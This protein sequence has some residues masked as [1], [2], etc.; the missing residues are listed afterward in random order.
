MGEDP[1]VIRREIEEQRDRLGETVDAL[2]Y[3]ADVK[4]RA[5]EAVTGKVTSVKEKIGGATPDVGAAKGRVGEATPDR[6]QVV[7]TAK[8]AGGLAQENPLGLAIG[9][10]AVGFLAG[11]L[12]PATSVENETIGPVAD[13]I[14]DKVSEVGSEAVQHGKEVAQEVA[15]KTAETAQE[16]ARSAGQEHASQVQETAQSAAQDVKEEVRS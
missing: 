6:E 7:A 9:A 11:L 10:A 8:R 5:S 2:S 1:E 16:T 4:T 12:I 15:Q 3:K 13:Q 14:K